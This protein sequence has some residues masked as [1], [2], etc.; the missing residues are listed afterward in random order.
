[1]HLIFV[2]GLRCDA[3]DWSVQM[4][5]LKEV[6]TCVAVDLA[7]DGDERSPARSL[8]EAMAERVNDV[9]EAAGMPPAVLVGHSMGCRVAV[10][11]ARLL[12]DAIRG[13]VL[14]EGSRRAVG[15]ADEAVRRWRNR[16]AKENKARLMHDFAGMFSEATPDVFRDRVLRRAA[17]LSGGYATRLV[18]DMTRWDATE[19]PAALRSIC[20]PILILQSTRKEPGGERRPIGAEGDSAWLRLVAE[21]AADSQVIR[22]DGIGH[23]PQVEAPIIVNGAIASFVTRL[24]RAGWDGRDAE[25]SGRGAPPFQSQ[26]ER[27]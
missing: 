9:R 2:H 12:P 14:I 3:A 17:A 1:M 7:R 23:F 19:A 27:N 13:L 10:E 6:A 16:S 24:V 21:E 5:F 4:D 15:D 11:A 18:A 20:A 8:V 25:S 26:D 22:L